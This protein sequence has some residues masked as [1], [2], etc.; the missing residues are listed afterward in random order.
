MSMQG[1]ILD[2]PGNQNDHFSAALFSINNCV[3]YDIRCIEVESTEFLS[4]S[5]CWKTNWF[6]TLCLGLL[7]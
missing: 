2:V 6:H 4:L 3:Y 1:K 5:V 7:C